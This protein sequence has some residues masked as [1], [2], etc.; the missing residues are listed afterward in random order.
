MSMITY[1]FIAFMLMGLFSTLMETQ[2]QQTFTPTSI[3]SLPWGD[4]QDEAGL[5]RVPAHHFAPPSFAVKDQ[6]FYLLDA[7]NQRVSIF[8][9]KT[10]QFSMLP[11]PAKGDD[12]CVTDKQQLYILFNDSQKVQKINLAGKILKTYDL[13][14]KVQ[15]MRLNCS[16]LGQFYI[17]S[18]TGQYY[19]LNKEQ[20]INY[21]PFHEYQLQIDTKNINQ[22]NLILRHLVLPQ[23]HTL[24]INSKKGLLGTLY[25]I[26]MDDN[27]NIYLVI[28]E[29]INEGTS[30]E[31]TQRFLQK[32]NIK[33]ELLAE[34]E[35][36]YSLYAYTLKDLV[37]TST[38]DIFQI[39]PLKKQFEI[40]RWRIGSIQTLFTKSDNYKKKL[41]SYTQRQLTDF[42]ASETEEDRPETRR[43]PGRRV[44]RKQ[45]LE[46]AR[47]YHN[48]RFCVD[49]ENI[50]SAQG[51]FL[52]NKKV[53]TPYHETGCYTAIPYKWGGNNS[54]NDFKKGLEA[55]KKAGDK[56]AYSCSKGYFGSPAAVGV[57]CS[58]YI[59]QA[60]QLIGK[61]S[62]NTLPEVATRLPSKNQLQAG[63][64]LN[65]RGYHVMLFSHKDVLGRLYVYEATGSKNYWKVVRLGY[66]TI[67][68]K[69]YQPYRYD[70]LKA[71]TTEDATD[72]KEKIP[73][74]LYIYG[75]TTLDGQSQIDYRAK[76]YYAD[77]SWQYVTEKVAWKEDSRYAE[78]IKS[79]LHT[80]AVPQNE[81]LIIQAIYTED[82]ITV[83]S[84]VKVK[85]LADSP[86]PPKPERLHLYGTTRLIEGETATYGAKVVY[87]DGSI[88]DVTDTVFW[89]SSDSYVYFRGATIY[90][91]PVNQEQETFIKALYIEEDN[92]LKAS[93]RVTIQ[94]INVD[95]LSTSISE[96][97]N[98]LK[99]LTISEPKVQILFW[100]DSIGKT[101]FEHDKKVTFYYKIKA[102]A[103]TKIVYLT[104]FNLFDNNHLT[105]IVNNKQIETDSL[106]S[107]PEVGQSWAQQT[108]FDEDIGI[109]LRK[110]QEHFKIV[111]SSQ[112]IDWEEF[113]KQGLLNMS[114][115]K[116]LLA[117]NELVVQ[118][119]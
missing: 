66:S 49:Q 107:L 55:G 68:L 33:G 56:C 89:S 78:F 87:S 31:E 3:T 41:F 112:P 8:N 110:G 29:I 74:R 52:I 63:D 103:E 43:R 95:Q 109:S 37:V 59:S 6:N 30:E 117:V 88:N 83:K 32:Y 26:G 39:L 15:P 65:Y 113:L 111:A 101:H 50:T 104:L 102:D 46:N 53:V 48:Y 108:I 91:Q 76:V 17:K 1:Y 5:I 27:K 99:K 82:E 96:T 93:V 23:S 61:Y 21:I 13:P 19:A 62:T 86:T 16:P 106:H 7:A 35:L 84:A 116:S 118:V 69:N 85:I 12:L 24:V 47:E 34:A 42:E 38:G 75:E 54:L 36:P 51:E 114:E 100:I 25:P 92:I 77:N 11:L 20:T 73:E 94:D 79:T 28:E 72:S 115:Q 44:T 90:A 97:I 70:Y 60:W 45:I 4:A 14:E 40:I 105:I 22:I 57:D 2:A 64:I 81:Q 58:G 67:Q 18:F 119:E 80:Q 71:A 10:Q 9:L 98:K